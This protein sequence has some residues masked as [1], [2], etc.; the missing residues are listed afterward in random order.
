VTKLFTA[1]AVAQLA[2]QG[3]VAYNGKLGTYLSGFPAS[4][5]D[6]V[7]IHHLLIR[8]SALEFPPGAG[9]RYSNAGYHVLGATVAQVTGQSYYDYVREHVFRAVGMTPAAPPAR[10]PTSRCTPTASGCR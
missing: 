4:V 1:V 9:F 6:T 5:A 3:T 10:R 7:T 8:R 2:Q